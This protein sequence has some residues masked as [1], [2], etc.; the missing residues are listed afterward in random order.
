MIADE[1]DSKMA[2]EKRPW[3]ERFMFIAKALYR[4]DDDKSGMLSLQNI[5]LYLNCL[6]NYFIYCL[7]SAQICD[8]I[9]ISLPVLYPH[10]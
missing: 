8:H 6:Q 10:F 7:M 2:A 9:R 3:F 5:S 4:Y 1:I